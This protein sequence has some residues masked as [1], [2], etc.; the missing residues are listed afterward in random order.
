[1]GRTSI[2]IVG[3]LGFIMQACG[4]GSS[5]KNTGAA[6]TEPKIKQ[7]PDGTI[8]LNVA[9]ADCYSDKEDPSG[10]TAEWNVVVSKSGR[11]EV[12]ISSATTDTIDLKYEKPVLV[13]IHDYRIQAKPACDRIYQNSSDVS[14][15]YFKADSFLGS[16][17]IQD[18]GLFNVQVISEKILPAEDASTSGNEIAKLLSVSFKP[19]T[20]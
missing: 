20:R 15:P 3:T 12:W 11:Y 19:E 10:N 5:D 9:K 18:T 2:I 14:H 16:M 1:M 7:Q 17:Y 13:S 4:G 6:N 8:S